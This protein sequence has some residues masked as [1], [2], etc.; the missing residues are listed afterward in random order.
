M[1]QLPRSI[2]R[3]KRRSGLKGILFTLTL[4]LT[5]V[6]SFMA[7]LVWFDDGNRSEGSTLRPISVFLREFV[8]SIGKDA[9]EVRVAEFDVESAFVDVP[10]QGPVIDSEPHEII[11]APPIDIIDVRTFVADG[12]IYRLKGLDGPARDAVC[13]DTQD[14]LWACGLQAR[15]AFNNLTRETGLNCEGTWFPE[16]EIARV[17]CL[18][19]EEDFATLL[20][21]AG[22]A[23]PAGET[24]DDD[25]IVAQHRARQ[26]ERGLW[27]GGWRYRE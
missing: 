9:D 2:L 13:L 12:I 6:F 24:H 11:V 23:R 20:V 7:A 10:P 3:R 8:A 18:A 15:A 1:H 17:S 26:D 27:N 25:L 5:F 22:F 14:H 21:E 4:A 19:G 16:L